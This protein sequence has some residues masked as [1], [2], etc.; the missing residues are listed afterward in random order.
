MADRHPA[1]VGAE[2]QE[3]RSGLFPARTQLL[4][5]LLGTAEDKAIAQQGLERLTERVVSGQHLV[6]SPRSISP[7]FLGKVG[8]GHCQRRRRIFGAIDL[9]RVRQYRRKRFSQTCELAAV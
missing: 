6:L 4:I 8:A 1:P 5:A 2:D 3:I 7:V 9:P